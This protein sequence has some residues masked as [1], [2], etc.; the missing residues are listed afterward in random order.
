MQFQ[1]LSQIVCLVVEDV[2]VNDFEDSSHLFSE[3]HKIF[4]D[5]VEVANPLTDGISMGPS[6]AFIPISVTIREKLSMCK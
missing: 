2:S 4:E 3:S 5:A 6:L 1:H